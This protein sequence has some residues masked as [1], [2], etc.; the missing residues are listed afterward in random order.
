MMPHLGVLSTINEK[1]ATD[2]FVRDCMVY[3]GT[4][5]APIGQGK[6][7]DRC[8]DYEI[9]WPDG[10]TDKGQLKF[11]EL[12]TVSTGARSAGHDQGATRQRG[13]ILGQGAGVAVT[14]EVH[15]GVVGLLLDGRGRPFQ[16][17]ADQP[18]RVAAL[19]KWFKAVG[20]VS[21]SR[22]VTVLEVLKAEDAQ[23]ISSR[24][25]LVSSVLVNNDGSFLYSRPNRHG[26]DGRPPSTH[27]AAA[28][29]ASWSRSA[30]WSV[31]IKWWRG[32][33]CRGKSFRSISPISWA[34][35]RMRS[36]TI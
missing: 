17:P 14:K 32:R 4:C 8:A 35:R 16:L 20:S 24:T 5:V 33:S 29:D 21:D 19:T 34:W 30:I 7:G 12:Q 23:R 13:R 25:A 2:V 9:T 3:L 1:A 6:D 26:T 10:R 31:P 15:G 11:G 28:R 22:V 27:V 36:K 18:G